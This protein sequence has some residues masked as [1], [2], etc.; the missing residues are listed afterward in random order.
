MPLP[1][2]IAPPARPRAA[3]WSKW[4]RR[5]AT[6]PPAS[7]T[8]AGGTRAVDLRRSRIAIP[9]PAAEAGLTAFALQADPAGSAATAR[10]TGL[11]MEA[12]CEPLASHGTCASRARA[13]W[14][15]SP[16]TDQAGAG[17][18]TPPVP[19]RCG[20]G[21]PEISHAGKM[22]PASAPVPAL[23]TR[24]R[25]QPRR[26]CARCRAWSRLSWDGSAGGRSMRSRAISIESS[27]FG[28]PEQAQG[29][30]QSLLLG[31]G[32]EAKVRRQR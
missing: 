32:C 14:M 8:K 9:K 4:S 10:G 24:R 7:P 22:P 5:P 20:L 26:T 2:V 31:I 3:L 18:L 13:R 17:R 30:S 21:P 23:L 1:S 19:G 12:P 16:E 11:V 6:S 28:P 15:P 27:L 29:C 25:A